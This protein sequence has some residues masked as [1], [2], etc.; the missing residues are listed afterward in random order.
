MKT[1]DE[2]M[3]EDEAAQKAFTASQMQT[4]VQVECGG[5]IGW[6]TM[7]LCLPCMDERDKRKAREALAA[8]GVAEARA[9][10]AT[11]NESGKHRILTA[12]EEVRRK[13]LRKLLEVQ[14]WKSAKSKT[15]KKP[16][17]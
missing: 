10:L 5:G 13:E 9:A 2:L 14:S 4:G 16:A 3:A 17:I 8:V 12:E 15:S 11:L 7:Y 6:T 1:M